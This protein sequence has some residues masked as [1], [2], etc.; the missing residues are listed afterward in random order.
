MWD[1]LDRVAVEHV[2]LQV[3]QFFLLIIIPTVFCT[4]IHPSAMDTVLTLWQLTSDILSCG[5]M[6]KTPNCR[7]SRWSVMVF[8]M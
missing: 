7:Y 3:L 8:V 6:L 1:L 4:Y 5:V 2:L